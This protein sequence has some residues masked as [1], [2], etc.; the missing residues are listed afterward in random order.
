MSKQISARALAQTQ[1]LQPDVAVTFGGN[2][3]AHERKFPRRYSHH[4]DLTEL[5]DRH[6]Q[7]NGM[8]HR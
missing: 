3:I 7:D 1:A 8:S 2:G 5:E 4:G 6:D